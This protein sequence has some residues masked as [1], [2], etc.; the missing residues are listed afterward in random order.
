MKLP[1]ELKKSSC[2]R[3]TK[4][5]LNKDY[6]LAPLTCKKPVSSTQRQSKSQRPCFFSLECEILRAHWNEPLNSKTFFWFEAL[7]KVAGKIPKGNSSVNV[8]KKESASVANELHILHLQ[9]KQ[10]TADSKD[11]INSVGL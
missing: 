4:Q 7:K 5:V 9:Y 1:E 11:V 8:E 6:F 2:L 3:S 10:N